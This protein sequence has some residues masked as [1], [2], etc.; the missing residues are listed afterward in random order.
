MISLGESPPREVY[1]R[2]P[3]AMHH[4]KYSL[5]IWMFRGQFKLSAKEEKALRDLKIFIIRTYCK[6]WFNAPCH[7]R[8]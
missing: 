8:P 2:A 3:G 5:E 1:F 4:A 6:A 7:E